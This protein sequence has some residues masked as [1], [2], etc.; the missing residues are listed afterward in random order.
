VRETPFDKVLAVLEAASAAR[1]PLTVTE[2]SGTVRLP[3]PTVHRL[4]AQLVE[5]GLLKRHLTSK[6]VMPGTRLMKLGVEAVQTSLYADKPHALLKSLVTRVGEFAQISMVVDGE[7]ICV[8]SASARR[9]SG[10]HL[11]QGNRAPLH[12]TSIGKLYLASMPDSEL[13]AWLRSTRLQRMADNTITR[14]TELHHHCQAIRI[15]GWGSCNEELHPGVV[16]CGVRLPLR[17]SSGFI[18]LCISAPK[19]RVN[20]NAIVEYV[21]TLRRVAQEIANV[22]DQRAGHTPNAEDHAD[23]SRHRGLL[24]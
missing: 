12:C 22:F 11:E 1:R 7:L 4:V 21:P 23:R 10:L 19:A 13:R 17:S 9:Q 16:G 5:R 6:K 18:G 2:L 8:D 14:S 24:A 15:Q 20:Y 3:V